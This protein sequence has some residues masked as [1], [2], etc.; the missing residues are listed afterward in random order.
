MIDA[1][2]PD[3]GQTFRIGTVSRLTGVPTDTLRVWERRYHVVTPVRSEA[4]T[5]H[6]AAEDVGRLSLI[7]RLVDGGDAISSVANLSLRELRERM[8]SADR[9]ERFSVSERPCRVLVCGPY[10]AER[11]RAES[12]RQQ[13]IQFLGFFGSA[14]ALPAA[15]GESADVLVLELPTLHAESVREVNRLLQCSGAVRVL[16]VYGFASRAALDLLDPARVVMRRSPVDIDALCQTCINM[17]PGVR[18]PGESGGGDILEGLGTPPVRRFTDAELAR[19]SAAPSRGECD[20]PRHVVDLVASLVA[21]ESYSLECVGRGAE[22][23]ALIAYM[24]ACTARAR[25][26]M[27]AALERAVTPEGA[28]S[29]ERLNPSRA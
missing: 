16:L 11:L 25:A 27:E 15:S 13:G 14:D 29:E 10:L 18:V 1:D 23:P 2:P 6:Y 20:W 12:G 7:K 9:P 28:D 3:S 5:R 4:G 22:D 8:R 24:S 21:F 19:L 26:L 17:V